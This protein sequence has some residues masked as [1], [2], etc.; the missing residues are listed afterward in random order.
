VENGLRFGPCPDRS[1]TRRLHDIGGKVVQLGMKPREIDSQALLPT[2]RQA[3]EL[4]GKRC[5]PG[6][7]GYQ[8][9]SGGSGCSVAPGTGSVTAGRTTARRSASA[10]RRPAPA[11]CRGNLTISRPSTSMATLSHPSASIRKADPARSGKAATIAACNGASATASA[12]ADA[13]G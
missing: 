3:P 9:K 13:A 2:G 12:G 6:I 7:L 10:T 4:L 5:S 1:G 8:E 11:S